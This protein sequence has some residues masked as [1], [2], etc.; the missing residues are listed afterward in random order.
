MPAMLLSLGGNL[1]DRKALTDAAVE[2]IAAL[3]GTRVVARSGYYRTEPVGPISQEW[4]L[5]TAIVVETT[6][7]PEALAIAGKAI[8]ATLGRDRATEI[9]WGPRPID[10][11]V[12]D[13]AKPE[14]RA[15]VLV[16][17]ADIAPEAILAGQTVRQRLANSEIK[18]IEKLDWPL[19]LA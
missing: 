11:D 6:L 10:I 8:E 13:P 9:S 19:P 2:R 18:G 15:F 12:L 3:P 16:P 7:T 17:L 4:F 14:D 5:N 1:G